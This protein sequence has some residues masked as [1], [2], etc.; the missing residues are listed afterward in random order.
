MYIMIYPQSLKS[1]ESPAECLAI[2][3]ISS[4]RVDLFVRLPF[5]FPDRTMY[6]ADAYLEPKSPIVGPRCLKLD[7]MIYQE[8]EISWHSL[9]VCQQLLVLFYKNPACHVIAR[10]GPILF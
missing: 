10:F 4:P 8:S 5:G 1:L 3:R 6:L 9:R 2:I 7:P